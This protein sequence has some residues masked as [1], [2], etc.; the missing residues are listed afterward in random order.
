MARRSHAS[1]TADLAAVLTYLKDRQIISTDPP[2]TLLTNAKKIHRATYSLILWRFRLRG[3]PDRARVFVEE[4]ASDALQIL[5]QSLMGYSKTTKLLTRGIIEN[6][7]RH[8]YFADHPIEFEKMNQEA[9]WFMTMAELFNYAFSHPS[10]LEVEPK[11]DSINRLSTLYSELS[12][13]VH[14]QRVDNLEMRTALKKIIYEDASV[15]ADVA[16]VERCA[17]ATN[18]VLARF[19]QSKFARFQLEDQRIILDSMPAKARQV[20]RDV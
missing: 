1:V 17:E 10:F 3:L 6:V 9:K 19:H 2:P 7:L 8:L 18:F 20:W 12:A 11:F 14:G 15:E 16:L 5:P 13:G 4:I